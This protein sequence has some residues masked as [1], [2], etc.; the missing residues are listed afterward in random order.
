MKKSINAVCRVVAIF[1]LFSLLFAMVGCIGSTKVDL[2]GAYGSVKSDYRREGMKA[3]WISY[4]EFQDV[5]FSTEENFAADIKE[6]FGNAKRMGLNTVIVHAR[7]F[8]DA[9]YK[10]EIF[11]Y[12]HIMTGTQGLTRALTRWK[13][14]WKTPTTSACASRRG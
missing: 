3:V 1:T 6:M 5:D 9:F 10:S 13:L 11:P 12:S 2:D 4:I 7:S 14:W 8:G